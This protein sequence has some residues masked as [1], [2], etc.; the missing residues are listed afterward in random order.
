MRGTPPRW[1]ARAICRISRDGRRLQGE[2]LGLNELAALPQSMP[3]AVCPRGSA[4]AD[5]AL[6]AVGAHS[7]EPGEVSA[8]GAEESNL[9]KILHRYTILEAVLAQHPSDRS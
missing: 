3:R 9:S 5:V 7:D 4:R 1:S 2:H 6:I 8:P